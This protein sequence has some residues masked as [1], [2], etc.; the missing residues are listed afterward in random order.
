MCPGTLEV[1]VL[2][3]ISDPIDRRDVTDRH[4]LALDARESIP[5]TFLHEHHGRAVGGERHDHDAALITPRHAFVEP[6]DAAERPEELEARLRRE[7][8]PQLHAHSRDRAG[9]EDLPDTDVR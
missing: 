5:R 2:D 3:A 8:A 7:L 1:E 4:V 6:I 9:R